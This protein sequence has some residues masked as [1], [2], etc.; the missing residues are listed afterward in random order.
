LSYSPVEPMVYA[1]CLQNQ[2]PAWTVY[3]TPL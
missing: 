2:P 1:K 3:A